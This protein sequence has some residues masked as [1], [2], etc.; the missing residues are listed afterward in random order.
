MTTDENVFNQKG[1]R[2][3]DKI[4]CRCEEV[5]ELE[6]R[7]AI[8]KYDLDT[9]AEVKRATRAGMGLCQGR[10]CEPAIRRILSEETGKDISEIKSDTS[11]P[12]TVPVETGVIAD[13]VRSNG[14]NEEN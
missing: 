7:E 5:T 11:R 14:T 1:K 3:P 9:V 4:I 13:V 2:S 10:S 8:R 6:I 12:P